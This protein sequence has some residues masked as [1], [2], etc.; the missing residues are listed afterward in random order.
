M[1]NGHD[2]DPRT[3]RSILLNAAGMTMLR[4]TLLFGSAGVALALILTPVADRFSRDP[5]IGV[6]LDYTA[7]GSID[8][9]NSYTIRR[10]VLQKDAGALCILRPDG[11]RSGD[12]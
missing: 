2:G 12:C 8:R 4:A 6:G 7:T 10:S 5:N 11:R 1:A 9:S 3:R